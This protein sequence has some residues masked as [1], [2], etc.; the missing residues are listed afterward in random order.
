MINYLRKYDKI[1]LKKEKNDVYDIFNA[2]ATRVKKAK[3]LASLIKTKI[4]AII[5]K[6]VTKVK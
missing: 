1:K 4:D 2:Y 5:S 3:V 6:A